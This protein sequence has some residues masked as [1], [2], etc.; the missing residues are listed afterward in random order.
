MK[1]LAIIGLWYCVIAVLMLG[2]AA[3]LATTAVLDVRR[4]VD[5]AAQGLAQLS[6]EAGERKAAYLDL[7]ERQRSERT[8]YSGP[9]A[10][11]SS[12]A[13]QQAHQAYATAQQ[14]LDDRESLIINLREEQYAR[15]IGL[16]PYVLAMLV[17]A[18]AAATIWPYRRPAKSDSA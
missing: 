11:A 15:A 1:V 18:L 10:I 6:S 12:Y 13:V 5:L 16:I 14:R 9:E 2:T 4:Q 17:H 8:D 3:T 7:R